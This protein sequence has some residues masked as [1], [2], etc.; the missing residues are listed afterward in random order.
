MLKKKKKLGQFT[1]DLILV[2]WYAGKMKSVDSFHQSFS[3]SWNG[4]MDVKGTGST[5][6][7]DE[8]LSH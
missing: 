5:G 7:P 2:N 8:Q 6:W 3:I 4:L 1:L